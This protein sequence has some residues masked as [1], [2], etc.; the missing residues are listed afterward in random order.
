MSNSLIRYKQLDSGDFFSAVTGIS[1][2]Y[3]TGYLNP[4][5]V[6]LT[7][8]QEMSGIKSF[9]DKITIK[10]VIVDTEETHGTIYI[11]NGLTAPAYYFNF[12]STLPYLIN[13]KLFNSSG[14]V[15]QDWVNSGFSGNWSTNGFPVISGHL[16]NKGYYD[17]RTLQLTGNQTISGNKTFNSIVTVGELQFTGGCGIQKNNGALESTCVFI[18]SNGYGFD[19]GLTLGSLNNGS[20]LD[21]S[22]IISCDWVG[23]AL[24]HSGGSPSLDW[25]RKILSGDWTIGGTGIKTTATGSAPANTGTVARWVTWQ[26]TGV[27]YKMPLYL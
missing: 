5:T 8:A 14:N 20:L 21:G 7:G 24:Y 15:I 2:P 3:T 6:L 27:N 19:G 12:P 22:L 16:L 26:I 1:Y 18:S 9:A 10:G 23:R 11:G 25:D 13:G 17:A 4:L